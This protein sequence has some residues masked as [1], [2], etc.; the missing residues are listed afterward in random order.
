[1]I[2]MQAPAQSSNGQIYQLPG[3]VPLSAGEVPLVSDRFMLSTIAAHLHTEITLTNRRLHA[4]RPNTLWG[5]IPT[6]H[7]NSDFPIENVAGVRAWTRISFLS[8]IVGFFCTMF[9][10]TF[11]FYPNYNLPF[12]VT[13]LTLGILLLLATPRQAIEIVNSGGGRI[14]FSVSAF[15]RGRS[16]DFAYNLTQALAGEGGQ[17]GQTVASAVQAVPQTASTSPTGRD[18]GRDPGEALTRLQ[19][20]HAQGLITADEYAS[21]RAEILARL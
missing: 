17:R 1:M 2:Q 7:A 14:R 13:F 15:E 16:A 11:L 5:L 4:S 6:G 12:G 20:L 10:M 19:Q 9:G 18:T 8:L 21:K 3:G